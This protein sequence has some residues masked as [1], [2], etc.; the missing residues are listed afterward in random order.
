MQ[1]A[2]AA[3]IGRPQVYYS[4]GNKVFLVT[5][6]PPRCHPS[7]SHLRVWAFVDPIK[8]WA[9]LFN[10]DMWRCFLD[11]AGVEPCMGPIPREGLEV[12]KGSMLVG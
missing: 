6:T 5:Y 4:A 8:V 11:R 9:L 1:D 10:Q 2:H 12:G 7:T 3:S